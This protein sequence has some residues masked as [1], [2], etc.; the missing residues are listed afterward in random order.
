MSASHSP[1]PRTS[2][3][4]SLIELLLVVAILGI[5]A[6][7]VAMRVGPARLAAE[8]AATRANISAIRTG[9]SHYE[10]AIG[11]LPATLDELVRVGD[12]NWPGPFLD[13]DTVPNDAWGGAFKYG[14]VAKRV[15]V[16][17]AGPDGTF[18]TEDDL[19]Q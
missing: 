3:G 4:F 10:M 11:K 7:V 15:R 16:T 19:W 9:I 14:I 5:L 13:A 12:E 1:L 6:G 8:I 17:S 18:A 2:A